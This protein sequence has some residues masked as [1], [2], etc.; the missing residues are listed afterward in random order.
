M[1][2]RAPN[3]MGKILSSKVA[4]SGFLFAYSVLGNGEEPCTSINASRVNLSLV[5]CAFGLGVFS[6]CRRRTASELNSPSNRNPRQSIQSLVT[7]YDC[8][9]VSQQHL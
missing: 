6:S 8:L 2:S 5:R 4:K 1:R 7:H 9:K 3:A